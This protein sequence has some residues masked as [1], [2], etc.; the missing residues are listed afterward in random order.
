[1]RIRSDIE[2]DDYRGF[3]FTSKLGNPFKHEG[4]VATMKRIVKHANQWEKERAE[5]E[6]REPV[7]LPAKLTPH[8]F[9]NSFATHLVLNEVPYEIA[10]VVIGHST[11]KTT[12]DVYS[13][14][15]N[16]N[17]KYHKYDRKY[18][19]ITHTHSIFHSI[20]YVNK[21]S[22]NTEGEFPLKEELTA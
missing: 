22:L 15:R 8:I 20:S 18:F 16:D 1:M 11:I 9:R 12:I 13:H 7:E 6:D 3:I 4:F 19:K 2:I 14:I 5:K 21:I 17:T 10:K